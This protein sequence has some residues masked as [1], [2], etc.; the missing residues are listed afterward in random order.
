MAQVGTPKVTSCADAFASIAPW[1]EVDPRIELFGKDTADELFE[2]A[3]SLR[4]DC[5]SLT[6][7]RY[8]G[9]P[10]YVIDCID[11]IESKV[12]ALLRDAWGRQLSYSQVELLA[13]CHS[14]KIPVFSSLGAGAKSDASMIQI[15]WVYPSRLT[16]QD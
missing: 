10:D 14:H 16:K 6:E 1:V 12:R 11:N 2:G 15:R 9:K 5:L 8:T 3:W 4:G 7:S 13:Y